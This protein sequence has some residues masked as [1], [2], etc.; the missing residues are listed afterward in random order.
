MPKSNI[1][2]SMGGRRSFIKIPTKEKFTALVFGK[3]RHDQKLGFTA[4]QSITQ[5]KNIGF[6]SISPGIRRLEGT[7]FIAGSA[8][9]IYI[10]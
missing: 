8:T 2:E 6:C 4:I 3:M 1:H 10:L 9:A 5:S 7:I